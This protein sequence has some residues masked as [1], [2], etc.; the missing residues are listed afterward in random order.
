MGAEI[1]RQPLDIGQQRRLDR[2]VGA[3][4]TVDLRHRGA[5]DGDDRAGWRTFEQR[6]RGLD[7]EY[8]RHHVDLE[9]APPGGFVHALSECADIRDKDV[10]A[11]ERV[12]GFRDPAPQRREIGDIERAARRLDAGAFELRDG[13][14][15]RLASARADRDVGTF[16]G[17]QPGDS[18]TNPAG[19]A[20]DD[21]LLPLQSEIHPSRRSLA[22]V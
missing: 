12:A 5:A 4:R 14:I 8:G 17:E 7:P 21:R 2:G 19:A 1:P 15:H 10:E 18:A 16:R 3:G 6:Q 22:S 20:G 9:P 13:P 11:A